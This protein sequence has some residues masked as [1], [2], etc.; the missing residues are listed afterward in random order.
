MSVLERDRNYGCRIN[1][2]YTYRGMRVMV[3]ENDLLRISLLLD[4]GT[5]IY[6][7]LYKPLD[8][9]F[10]FLNNQ[11]VHNPNRL[12]TN[13]HSLGFLTDVYD[14]GWHEQLPNSGNR[15]NFGGTEQ[16]LH[17]EVCLLPWRWS[18][19][20]DTPDRISARFWVRTY[21]TPFLLE[22]KLTFQRGKTVLSIEERV[23]NESSVAQ[24]FMWGHHPTLGE[25]FLDESCVIDIPARK[26]STLPRWSP[27]NRFAGGADFTWPYAPAESGDVLDLSRVLPRE[28]CQEDAAYLSE[29]LEGWYAVTNV[30]RRVGFGQVWPATIFPYVV[31]WMVYGGTPGYPWYRQN[32]NL[33]LEPQSSIPEGLSNSVQAGTALVLDGGDSLDLSFK[34]VVYTGIDGVAQISPDGEVTPR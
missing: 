2:D 1:D 26:G 17:G 22:K 11:G 13:A 19:L 12:P 31:L 15:S 9:D 21:R 34:T 30:R 3:M 5:T 8:I 18:V 20:E 33:A 25:A 24:H 7:Y 23:T 4:K 10:M 27:D 6:E 32:Y 14:G 28:A 29:L 16:G